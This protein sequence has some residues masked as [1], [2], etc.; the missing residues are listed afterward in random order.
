MRIKQV[1]LIV[2][3]HIFGSV[4]NQ[5]VADTATKVIE[6]INATTAKINTISCDFVQ[7]KH[8]AMLNDQLI[9]NG[10][11]KY[12]NP[13]KLRWE[14]STPY[15]YLFVFN[16]SKVYVKNRS[17]ANV[18]DVNTNKIFREV[19]RIMMNTVTGKALSLKSDFNVDVKVET[20][21]Y[22]IELTPVRKELKQLFKSVTLYFNKSNRY[23]SKIK[24]VEKNG[25]S[26]DIQFKNL[27]VNQPINDS[28]FAIPN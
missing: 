21:E 28:L 19:A 5:A 7:T 27:K 3:L 17:Q 10:T 11:M 4:Y 20:N 8:L 16:G 13:D 22:K 15:N 12:S 18:I 14:Y 2:L 23:I 6:E 24:I 26:T 25:D 9:S 1:A